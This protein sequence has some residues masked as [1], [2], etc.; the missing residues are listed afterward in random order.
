MKITKIQYS[1]L[2]SKTLENKNVISKTN[3]GSKVFSFNNN[4]DYYFVAVGITWE[5]APEDQHAV[6]NRDYKVQI[7]G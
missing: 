2:F 5:D 4:I 6:I 1:K 7:Q 3:V